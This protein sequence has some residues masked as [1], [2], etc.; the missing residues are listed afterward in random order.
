MPDLHVTGRCSGPS[1]PSPERPRLAGR[2]VRCAR[3]RRCPPRSCRRR[4]CAGRWSS[5][6]RREAVAPDAPVLSRYDHGL[7]VARTRSR[8]SPADRCR[9]DRPDT[10]AD[11]CA[12]Q[13]RHSPSLP[14]TGLKRCRRPASAGTADTGNRTRLVVANPRRAR[15]GDHP[16][17]RRGSGPHLAGNPEY[18]GSANP[19]PSAP[20]LV[21][22]AGISCRKFL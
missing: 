11:G 12:A 15:R 1:S 8:R 2:S 21:C 18:R 17:R 6:L 19:S 5:I 9:P 3:H 16:R 4:C 10:P 22:R 13:G 14:A 20:L 7:I